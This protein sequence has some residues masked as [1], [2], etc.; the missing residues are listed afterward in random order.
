VTSN[1]VRLTLDPSDVS[2]WLLRTPAALNR[3]MTNVRDPGSQ[4]GNAIPFDPGL[5][6]APLRPT[7]SRG[8]GKARLSWR[9]LSL[10]F[11]LGIRTRSGEAG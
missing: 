1:V 4:A 2:Y 3:T 8:A 7:I 5:Q 6:E 10:R 11:G 9:P